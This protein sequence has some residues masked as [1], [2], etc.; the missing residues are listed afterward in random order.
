MM[1]W[2]NSM[3]IFA[4]VD[5]NN[6]YASCERAFNPRLENKPIVVLSNNDG[7]IIARSNEAKK[8]GIPMGAPFFQWRQFCKKNGVY[9]FSS[10]YALYGDMSQRVMNILKS[11]C[12]D[13]EIY[14]I[15][16]AFLSLDALSN[17][18][19]V[20]FATR[21]R[22]TIKDCTGLPVSIGIATTKTL[23][24]IAN[25]IAKKQ[26]T[27]GVFDLSSLA[28]QEKILAAFPVG[29]I[30]GI[31]RQ[32]KNKLIPFGI[33]TAK[34][35]RDADLKNLRNNFSVVLEKTIQELRN[36]S[37]LPLE[38]IQPRK[39][40]I[41]S[42]SFGKPVFSLQDLEEAV[43]TY[44]AIA[45]LKLR[46]Q[47]SQAKGIYVFLQTNLFQKK[48]APYSVG[49]SCHLPLATINTNVM[50]HLAKK[51]VQEIFKPGLKYHKA[52]IMLLDI[53][54]QTIQ[55]YDIFLTQSH[56][57]QEHL[58]EVVDQINQKLGKHILFYC[59]EGIK[60]TWQ[61]KSDLR[62][63]RYTTQWS[64]IPQVTTK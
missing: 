62:S 47:K 18:D 44:T 31:G 9:V 2:A 21:V 11:F 41:S 26:T 61:I 52:G 45:C 17:M 48:S 14:S 33:A 3:A 37:C 35:L 51:C 58:T 22:T 40:I 13:M 19:L 53:S 7:C 60:K 5:C 56:Q 57:K 29:E 8:L 43:S 59:A 4:L 46:H 16:E 42:R 15:D 36:I 1:K 27:T 30:W 23:A 50:I 6:F 24:K 63:P 49:A 64:E 12:P 34:D 20:S 10:N 25:H 32:L 38:A 54:P 39:Q 28:T 55:Q